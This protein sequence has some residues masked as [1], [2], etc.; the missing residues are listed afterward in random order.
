MVAC[1]HAIGKLI[2]ELHYVKPETLRIALTREGGMF[3]L[4]NIHNCV[5]LTIYKQGGAIKRFIAVKVIEAN[6][7]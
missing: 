7:I 3:R 1:L 2:F 4:I 5:Q 6:P